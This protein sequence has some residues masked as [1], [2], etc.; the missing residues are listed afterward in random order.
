MR[1]KFQASFQIRDKDVMDAVANRNK[2]EKDDKGDKDA[3]ETVGYDYILRPILFTVPKG[4]SDAT[5]EGRR[6]EAEAL[7]SRFQNCELGLPFVRNLH[8][9]AVR[10]QIVKSSADLPPALREILDNTGVGHLT[11]PE[12]T[13]NGIEL[14][15]L[16]AK[17]ETKIDAPAMREARQTLFAE[18]F[19]A[20]SKRFLQDL[21]RAAMIEVKEPVKDTKDTK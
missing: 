14:F 8:D 13:Q 20:K 18:K 10:D 3:T 9:V 15:A 21:R 4:A 12:K 6:H 7:R 16:C 1:G 2:D 17:R 5:F 11:N 19:Q